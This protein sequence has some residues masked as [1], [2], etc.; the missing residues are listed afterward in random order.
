MPVQQR[1]TVVGMAPLNDSTWWM[2]LEVGKMVEELGLRA[3]QFL[4][5][6]CGEGTLLRR[7]ISV[8]CVLADEPENTA[9]LIFEVKG[10]GTRW[11]SERK[12]GDQVDVIGPLGNG[13]S[14]E[15]G[16]RCLLVGG[17]IGT[18]PLLGYAEAFRE[19]AVAVLGFRSADRVILEDR[20]R[21]ACKEVYLCTD[22]GSAGR[23]GFVDAQV[24]DILAKDKNFTAILACGPRPMLKSVAKAAAEYGVPCQVSMEERMA[25]GVGACLG[26]AIQMADGTMKHVCKDGPVFN[27][28]EVDWDV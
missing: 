22:D 25:C 11:L 10:E 8:A 23:H 15:Q 26:C 9:A 14:V 1:C 5:V 3:G 21:E 16:G 13:F 28:E 27:A 18:P 6:A 2:T 17:G 4:H 12:V 24:R 20:Y 7:P 19:N